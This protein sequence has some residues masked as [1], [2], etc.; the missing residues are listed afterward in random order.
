[1]SISPIYLWDYKNLCDFSLSVI[2]IP[3]QHLDAWYPAPHSHTNQHWNSID[4]CV[5]VCVCV[6]L[7]TVVC[8]LHSILVDIIWN[9]HK[10]DVDKKQHIFL[11]IYS[12]GARLH[13]WPFTK[14]PK[15]F[16]SLKSKK[17]TCTVNILTRNMY[18]QFPIVYFTVCI[19]WLLVKVWGEMMATVVYWSQSVSADWDALLLRSWRMFCV[20][21]F[22]IFCFFPIVT[23]F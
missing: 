5:C 19:C 6:C 12:H 11:C 10:T 13:V 9:I 14:S 18:L 20:L 2:K 17:C 21:Y 8:L 7:S 3:K 1:M 15:S 22:F 4:R 23:A 16:S